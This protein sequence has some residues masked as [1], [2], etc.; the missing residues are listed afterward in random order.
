MTKSTPDTLEIAKQENAQALATLMNRWLKPRGMTAKATREENCLHVIFEANQVPNLKVLIVFIRKVILNLGVVAIKT[1]KISVYL[2]GE[3]SPVCYEEIAL[4]P[5]AKLPPDWGGITTSAAG[6]EIAEPATNKVDQS[7]SALAKLQPASWLDTKQGKM[8]VILPVF[9]VAGAILLFNLN[10]EP[11]LPT[12]SVPAPATASQSANFLQQAVNQATRASNQAR[13][14]K[15][16]QEWKSI[17]TQ[18]QEALRLMQAVPVSD[19]K[20][21]LAQQKVKEYQRKLEYAQQ[22][23]KTSP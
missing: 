11:S 6:W 15:T 17:A 7:V 10:R 1:V 20:H 5:Q 16:Q 2:P 18:W 22:K 13:T 19:P 3:S 21:K 4:K 23:A 14:A 9:I 12:Q 8:L